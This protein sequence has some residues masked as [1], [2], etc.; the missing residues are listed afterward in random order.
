MSNVK[1][2]TENV[3]D[4]IGGKVTITESAIYCATDSITDFAVY[5]ATYL[6]F[7][8]TKDA[9]RSATRFATESAIERE[10]ENV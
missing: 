10:L 2:D 6:G 8:S 1:T 4:S 5:S 9:T 7:S 3:S